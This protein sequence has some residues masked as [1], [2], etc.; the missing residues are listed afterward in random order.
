[1]KTVIQQ[2]SSYRGMRAKM[3]SKSSL[4]NWFKKLV[5]KPENY[6][7]FVFFV[8]NIL[9]IL[10][11][12]GSSVWIT[13]FF[14]AF[15][16]VVLNIKI[17]NW[18]ISFFLVTLYTMQ[19]YVPNKY[20][21]IEVFKPGD[22]ILG[23]GS[24]FLGY[25]INLQNIFLSLTLIFVVRNLILKIWRLETKI[26]RVILPV[27]IAAVV[28]FIVAF[29]SSTR[30]SPYAT[31]SIV[32]LMQYM[33]MFIIALTIVV[34]FY[35]NRKM[36]FLIFPLISSSILLQSFISILQFLKQSWIG[37]PV[38]SFRWGEVFYGASDAVNGAFRVLGTFG[39]PN[40]FALIMT[41]MLSIIIPYAIS[42][43]KLFYVVSM[44]LC[45]PIIVLTQ[46]RSA[47]LSLLLVII[48][49]LSTNIKKIRKMVTKIGIS[50]IYALLILIIAGTSIVFIPR[51][52]ASINSFSENAGFPLRQ[53]MQKEAVAAI[54]M[55]PLSG[56][57]IGTNETV[58]LS[59]Y[60]KGYVYSFPAPVHIFY[61]QF[62]LECGFIG[63][64]AF[65]FPFLYTIR[66]IISRHWQKRIK[67]GDF[68]FIFVSGCITAGVYYLFQPHQ[69]SIEFPYLGIIL[70]FGM[71]SI[72]NI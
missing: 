67:I 44:V 52:L 46:S 57:G 21:I 53:E 27:I 18:A 12:I 65:L 38:E 50:R 37:L 13:I 59:L 69:G 14:F 19:F 20:Y 54:V 47:W 66:C 43:K 62:L 1:M 70:G 40:Q 34:I 32:W 28:F 25:G 41:L 55:K 11:L 33:E 72:Q 48:F 56:Y 5:S 58:L 4:Y 30:F 8:V 63:L 15:V 22:L 9:L 51:L 10:K 26:I 36:L 29:Y 71:L 45:V 24:Y 16:G 42:S 23:W 3:N 2:Y 31:L 64:L 60:P 35:N 68:A 39:Q 17:K 7:L 49:G 6:L 61:L